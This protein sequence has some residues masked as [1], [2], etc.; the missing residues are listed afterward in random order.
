G[1]VAQPAPVLSG[2][3]GGRVRPIGCLLPARVR[4]HHS[5]V[6]PATSRPPDDAYTRRRTLLH[7]LCPAHCLPDRAVWLAHQLPHHGRHP[8]R[9]ICAPARLLSQL[10]L[11]RHRHRPDRAAVPNRDPPSHQNPPIPHPA[12]S[13]DG[14]HVHAVR[15]HDQPHPA[16]AGTRNRLLDRS[17]GLR[18]G[19][20]R[21]SHR[22]ARLPITDPKNHTPTP[23]P[24]DPRFPARPWY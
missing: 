11:V 7:C 1:V 23:H 4:C 10:H 16:V 3:A 2:L 12:S 14:S 21:T 18:T 9:R 20:R 17:T 6:R 13:D 8:R 5:L 24:G 15:R 22:P 19:G